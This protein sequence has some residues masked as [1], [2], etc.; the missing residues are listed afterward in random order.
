MIKMQI[1]KNRHCD[2]VFSTTDSRPAYTVIR[3]ETSDIIRHLCTLFRVRKSRKTPYHP[4]G[5]PVCERFN[6]TL[7]SML[8][9]LTSDEKVNWKSHLPS[10]VRAYNS[11]KNETTG[12]SPF[13]L[14]FGRHPRLPAVVAF[15]L[16]PESHQQ[17]S[18]PVYVRKFQ[19]RLHH[20]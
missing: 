19:E 15:G 3:A 20:A 18:V 14:M 16:S 5:K 2:T 17:E 9:T 11:S 4:I 10:L 1:P 12:F 7:L 8:G 13:Y 6:S